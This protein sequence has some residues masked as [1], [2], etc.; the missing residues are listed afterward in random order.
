MI[1]DNGFAP[2]TVMEPYESGS[3]KNALAKKKVTCMFFF[4]TRTWTNP[5]GM[6]PYRYGDFK[7]YKAKRAWDDNYSNFSGSLN[8]DSY[9]R[10]H[11]I[12]YCAN[13]SAKGMVDQFLA[14]G[15]YA[16]KG[17]KV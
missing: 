10:K 15:Y 7:G 12:K 5:Q 11:K 8:V 14:G 6:K 1:V 9:F 2:A 4:D 17:I 3:P 16:Y 13:P